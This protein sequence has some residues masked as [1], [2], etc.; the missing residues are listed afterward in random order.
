MSND[1]FIREVNEE[2]RQDKL[3]AVWTRYGLL[4]AGVVAAILVGTAAWVGWTSWNE[5]RANRSGDAFSQAL[6]LAEAGR[7]DEALEA[8]RALEADGYGSYPVLARMRQATV[9]SEA[10]DFDGAVA[11]FD[12]VAADTA[13]PQS[14]RDMAR[15]RAALVLVDHGTAAQVAERTQPLID[16]ANAM[17]HSAREAMGLAAWKEGDTATATQMFERITADGQAPANLRQ[18]AELMLELLRGSAAAT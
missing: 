15:L 2:L 10:G 12:S 17:R 4:I 16:D 11:A 9:M 7:N 6:D 5:Q 13:I 18:R 3:K 14:I 8:L 1:S